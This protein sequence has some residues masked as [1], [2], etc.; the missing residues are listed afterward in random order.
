MAPCCPSYIGSRAHFQSAYEL[1][2]RLAAQ[3]GT[4]TLHACMHSRLRASCFHVAG[5]LMA[6]KVAV[7]LLRRSDRRVEPKWLFLMDVPPAGPITRRFAQPAIFIGAQMVRLSREIAGTLTEEAELHTLIG[8]DKDEWDE[9]L[10][11]LHAGEPPIESAAKDWEVALSTTEQLA[12]LGQVV[13]SVSAIKRTKKRMEVYRKN[14][15]LWHRQDAM[16]APYSNPSGGIVHVTS[17]QRRDFFEYF[18]PDGYSDQLEAYGPSQHMLEIEGKH[19]E[20][21]QRI[22]TNR[23]PEVPEL[24]RSLLA[25]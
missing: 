5:A 8:V 3:A 18:Y 12:A 7:E 25:P 19:T 21:V 2:S 9:A 16:P 1:N 4:C 15:L 13:D 23:L 14:L 24:I 22:S 10:R 6:Q 20:V 11:R 17:T